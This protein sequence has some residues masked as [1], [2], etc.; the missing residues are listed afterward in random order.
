MGW[1]G[2]GGGGGGGAGKEGKAGGGGG[3][4]GGVFYEACFQTKLS[5]MC[6]V[7]AFMGFMI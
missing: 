2:G 6:I 4:G 5:K 7:V 3:G 1:G